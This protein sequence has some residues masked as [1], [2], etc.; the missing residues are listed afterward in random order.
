MNFKPLITMFALAIFFATLISPLL[1]AQTTASNTTLTLG[2]LAPPITTFFQTPANAKFIGSDP[3]QIPYLWAYNLAANGSIIPGIAYPPYEV[4]GSN[5]TEWIINLVS[6]SMK[7][8]DGVPINSSDLAFSYGLYLPTGPYANLS[9]VDKWGG[10]RGFVKSVAIINSTA[11]ELTTFK[12]DPLFPQ[13]TFLYAIYPW[14]YYKQFTGYNVLQTKSIVSGPCDSSF[15]PVNYTPGS[16][17]MNLVANPLSP[18]WHGHKPTI[19][20]LVIKFFTSDSA[21]INALATGAVDAAAITPSDV[22]ALQSVSSLAIS[23]VPGLTQMTLYLRTV[24]YPWS[25]VD[26]RRA[27]LYLVNK[28]E[29]NNVLYNG[30]GIIG[31]PTL[32]IPSATEFW[33]GPAT[34]L[35]NYNVSAA[36]SLLESAGLIRSSSGSWELPNGTALSITI[37]VENSDPNFVRAAQLVASSW[38]ADGI[39]TTVSAVEVS[40]TT[41]DVSQGAFQAIIY[42]PTLA[43]TPARIFS[44]P[45]NLGGF[46]YSSDYPNFS[47]LVRQALQSTSITQSISLLKQAELEYAQQAAG[48]TI[49]FPPGYVAYND[50]AFTNWQPALNQTSRYEV[51]YADSENGLVFGE[52]VLTSVT[53]VSTTPIPTTSTTTTT[54]YKL[55]ALTIIIIAIVIIIVAL[56]AYMLARRR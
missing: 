53:P 8:S 12:P 19:Q 42:Q 22:A 2:T 51:F 50:V 15:C 33:P 44:R 10:I 13:I 56:V 34:P 41:T 16:Y 7:W 43:P 55:G 49:L 18:S 35:Y 29:I 40:Q 28:T 25:N 39:A 27:L 24:G 46:S 32:L 45:F 4:P 5:A 23:K 37:T 36:N 26:F 47:A 48:T 1:L 54:A 3:T 31:N 11:V 6:S 14:H 38:Q 17:V 9:V 52:N 30:Q 21:L 20:N